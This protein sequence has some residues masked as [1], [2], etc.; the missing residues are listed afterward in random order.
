ML[1]Q[2]TETARLYLVL[3]IFFGARLGELNA[4]FIYLCTLRARNSRRARMKREGCFK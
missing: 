1:T 3:I 4:C 2:L